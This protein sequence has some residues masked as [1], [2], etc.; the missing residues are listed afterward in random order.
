M[1]SPVTWLSASR[2]AQVAECE[3]YALHVMKHP[4]PF[5][6]YPTL[7]KLRHAGI[8]LCHK[9]ELWPPSAEEMG[10]IIKEIHSNHPKWKTE[11]GQDH[12]AKTIAAMAALAARAH[13]WPPLDSILSVEGTNIPQTFAQQ[14]YD[15]NGFGV[16]VELDYA[17][18]WGLR[19]ILDVVYQKTEVRNGRTI[20]ILVARDWKGSS[21]DYQWQARIYAL[22]MWMI[23]PGFDEYQFEACFVTK[24]CQLKT[25]AYAET[26]DL[27]LPKSEFELIAFT[28]EQVVTLAR[29]MLEIKKSGAGKATPCQKCFKCPIKNT[30]M[31]YKMDQARKSAKRMVA[32]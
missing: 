13:L 18:P 4:E 9:I 2:L 21:G 22:A 23:W 14:I 16:P 29:R 3:R 28:Y 11:I 25:Y 20:R 15:G 27:R 24:N 26:D 12:L 6:I 17:I 32:E 7:G 19:G 1:N 10:E 30:C 5:D 31:P 8:E